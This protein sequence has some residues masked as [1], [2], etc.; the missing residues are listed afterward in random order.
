MIVSVRDKTGVQSALRL[1]KRPHVLPK[2]A[3]KSGGIREAREV[4]AGNG[5]ELLYRC[6][7][8]RHISLGDIERSH[9]IVSS[10][11]DE[12][13]NGDIEP[14]L[15]GVVRRDDRAQFWSGE[16]PSLRCSLRWHMG[17][18]RMPT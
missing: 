7:N 11:N 1:C 18:T 13:W 12:E 2:R 4:A 6:T 10:L 9:M 14:E 8:L 16:I 5:D 17:V 3:D 15:S